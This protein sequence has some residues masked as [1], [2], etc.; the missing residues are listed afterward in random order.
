M[1]QVRWGGSSYKLYLS[2]SYSTVT[3]TYPTLFSFPSIDSFINLIH[4]CYINRNHLF[5]PMLLQPKQ[6]F[7]ITKQNH[8]T[9]RNWP[10]MVCLFTCSIVSWHVFSYC[11][12]IKHNTTWLALRECEKVHVSRSYICRTHDKSVHTSPKAESLISMQWE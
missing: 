2:L 3:F 11:H 4:Y 7:I 6:C 8:G 1:W 5:F 12:L 10:R 9:Y